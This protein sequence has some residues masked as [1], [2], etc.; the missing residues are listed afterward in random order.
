MPAI[1]PVTTPELLMLP[2]AGALLLQ[3]PPS[4][5]SVSGVVCP[6]QTT[7]VPDMGK[8][9]FTTTAAITGV[10]VPI[11]YEMITVPDEIPVTI[12][13]AEP[14]VAIEVILLPQAPPGTASLQVVVEPTHTFKVPVIGA[15]P[16]ETVTVML[17]VQ[18]YRSTMTVAGPDVIPVTIPDVEPIV[19]MVTGVQLQ[20]TPG[21][22]S[23]N[24]TE[25]PAQKL[26]GPEIGDGD[27]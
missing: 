26:V 8:I 25:V 14:I 7:G 21:V 17:A 11:V 13:E 10:Q 16:G 18:P 19:S 22:A 4:A 23:V 20:V 1:I 5:E 9:G 15:G 2:V 27:V 12:P 6:T 24:E 3:V